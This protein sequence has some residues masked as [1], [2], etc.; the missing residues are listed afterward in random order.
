MMKKTLIAMAALAAT[1]AF[2]Q[3]S[4]TLYGR[5]D[6]G[7]A[8]NTTT[9]T[10]PAGVATD[11]R[12]N[13]INN[14]GLSTNLW[15]MRGTEDLGGGLKANFVL[16][17]DL[18]PDNGTAGGLTLARVSTLGL[19]GNF[20]TVNM[21]RNYT[22]LFWTITTN[23]LFSTTGAGTVNNFPDGARFSDMISYSTPNTGGFVATA[24][25]GRNNTSTTAVATTSGN[26]GLSARFDQGPLMVGAAYGRINGLAAGV[27]SVNNGTAFVTSYNFGVAKLDGSY[28]RGTAQANTAVNTVTTNRE[29]NLGLTM[30]VGATTL[31]VGLGRNT[32]QATTAGVAGAAQS[33]SDFVIG[34]TYSLSKRTTAYVKTGRYAQLGAVTG[35]NGTK[36]NTSAFGLRHTF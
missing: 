32:R 12:N 9:T 18:T 17:G 31:L 11:T 13:G 36:T 33:G 5:L 23:D 6:M 21:G 20:G 4:V 15:G 7:Y 25:L 16:E 28:I 14:G 34:A 22:P 30:P 26:T 10:T 8:L 35:V 3:S 2:A 29:T 24:M 19:S 1:S 27:N